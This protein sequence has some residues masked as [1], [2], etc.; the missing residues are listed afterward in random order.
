MKYNRAADTHD[1]ELIPTLN[2]QYLKACMLQLYKHKLLYDLKYH[3]LSN[4]RLKKINL[5][6][7]SDS[8]F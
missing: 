6:M 3:F 5:F 1:K 8:S 2:S 7:W 4:Y